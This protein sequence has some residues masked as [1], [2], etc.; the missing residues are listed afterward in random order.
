MGTLRVGRETKNYCA[1]DIEN[2]AVIAVVVGGGGCCEIAQNLFV[3]I[4]ASSET[5]LQ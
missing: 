1:A 3:F 2:F 5:L 4:L